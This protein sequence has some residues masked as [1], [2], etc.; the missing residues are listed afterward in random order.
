MFEAPRQIGSGADRPDG[1]A[2]GF[3]PLAPI[4]FAKLWATLWRGRLTILAAMLAALALAVLF[5]LFA[6]QRFTATTQIL[7]EPGDLRAVGNE[8]NPASQLS[9]AQLMQVES[10]V[11]ELTSDSVLRRVVVAQGLDHDPEFVR[12]PSPLASL[13]GAAKRA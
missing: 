13:F 3:A 10:Q 9:E 7:I 6:P 5:I 1:L 8:P 4:D 11:Q 12:P 2:R